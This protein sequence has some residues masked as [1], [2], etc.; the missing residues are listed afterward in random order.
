MYRRCYTRFLGNTSET[1]E[2]A[3]PTMS[4]MNQ[5]INWL[6]TLNN[7]NH[8]DINR[9]DGMFPM[10][11]KYV[12]YGK[13]IAGSGTPHLQGYVQLTYKQR[14][15]IMKS[16]LPKA[17]WT[18]ADGTAEQNVTYCSKDGSVTTHGTLTTKG[19]KSYKIL[20]AMRS[21][22]EDPSKESMSDDLQA[23]YIHNATKL[24]F[25]I[26]EKKRD[27]MKSKLRSEMQVD[28]RKWQR[29]AVDLLDRQSPREI[30]FVIDDT[31]SS[32]KTWLG[33]WLLFNR[34]C[35][36]TRTTTASAVFYKWTMEQYVVFDLSRDK[37]D[38]INYDSIEEMKDGIVT[39]TKYQ[40]VDKFC[41][42]VKVIVFMNQKPDMTKLSE[43]RYAIL[44]IKNVWTDEKRS[45]CS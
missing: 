1:S 3:K 10:F 2:L 27:I 22:L 17:H 28:L 38:T 15:S 4:Q 45:K 35:C 39:S 31:G 13:D 6:F 20:Q 29:I 14:L 5:R 37:Q 8:H 23:P 43:D 21:M 24:N 30:L 25:A 41:A 9:V 16:R 11:A 44:N 18:P 36:I 33:K 32:G 12:I 40:V 42:N 7:Y 19:S 26:M 34:D